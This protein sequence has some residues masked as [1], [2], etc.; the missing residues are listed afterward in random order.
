MR[1]LELKNRIML[2]PM[3]TYSAQEGMANDF[4]LAHI[5]KFAHGGFGLVFVEATAVE[6]R[7]RIT[8][9]DLGVWCDEQVAPLKRLA[10]AVRAG[11]AVPALQ[12]AHA[13]RKACMQRPWFGNSALNAADVARGDLPWAVVGAS[14]LPMDEGWLT[15]H[16][17]TLQE[18]EALVLAWAA[19]ARRA[20]AAGFEV[21]EVHCAHGYLLHQFLSPLSNHR[22]DAYG[23]DLRGRMKLPLAIAQAVREVWPADKPVFVRISATDGVD[24]GWSLEDSVAFARALKQIGV[25]AIDCSSGGITGPSTSAR[26][27]RGLGFQVPFAQT[28]RAQADIATVAV[29]LILTAPQAD[30]VI[31]SG[32]ADLVAIGREALHNPH[33]ALHTAQHLRQDGSFGDWPQQY[34]WWLERR[35]R[36]LERS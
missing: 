12:L 25:D 32:A 4:H 1:G 24:N 27:P 21:V 29:G 15:P 11:G 35:A 18:L 23:G 28:V 7:G 33:W 19:A 17:L 13:G 2:S 3:C 22:S 9:G 6:A 16:A 34:G 20:L 10:D 31:Q 36:I 5:A 14:A 26:I 8:H 30:E